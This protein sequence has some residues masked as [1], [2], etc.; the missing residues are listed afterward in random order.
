MSV[1]LLN[2]FVPPDRAPTA[3]ALARLAALLAA[4]APEA[5]LSMTGTGRAYVGG[6]AAGE[7]RLWRRAVAGLADGRQLAHAA[8]TH[9]AV[10]SL[11]DP[12]FLAF[13]LARRLP[14]EILWL[15][16]TMDLYPHA[17]WAALGWRPR[18]FPRLSGRRPDLRLHLGPGQAAFLAGMEPR[19]APHLILPAG[20]RDPRPVPGFSPPVPPAPGEPI[21]LVYAG[22]HGQAHWGDALPLLAAACDPTRF[23][24]TVAAHGAGAAAVTTRLAGFSHVDLRGGPLSDAELDAAHVHLVSL[25]ENW[26][27][28][29]V[30]SKAISALSRGRPVLFFGAAASDVW[31]WA[32]G[33][34]WRIDPAPAAARRDLPGILRDIAA[35]AGL[36][37]ATERAARAG[38]RLRA[39]E[40]RALDVVAARLADLPTN[41][42]S[43]N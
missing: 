7:Q 6:G 17:V 22:N 39:A 11:T 41:R 40:S 28:V 29:C 20:V 42:R 1:A 21:R 23:R 10:L 35:P 8:A 14:P 5:K 15:E 36:A 27:H 19:A 38:D 9:A 2:R 3:A 12:P 26:T 34:G 4:R 33:G 37:A 31:G 32:D 13:H 30:P 16:W 43:T 24:L 25:Q 18:G